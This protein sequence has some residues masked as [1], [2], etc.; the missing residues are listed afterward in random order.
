MAVLPPGDQFCQYADGPMTLTPFLRAYL[1]HP[2]LEHLVKTG[3]C[4]LVS[5]LVYRCTKD[6]L[7]DESQNR[8]HRILGVAAEDVDFLREMGIDA[9][10]LEIFHRYAG[11]KDRQPL[12]RWQRERRVMRDVLPVLKY[13]TAHKLMKYADA[14]FDLLHPRDTKGRYRGHQDVVSEYRDYLDMCAKLDYAAKSKSVLFPKNLKKAHDR[15]AKQLK[16]QKDELA[17]RNFEE[18]YRR[19]T[20]HLDFTCGGLQVVYPKS[21]KALAEEGSALQH[22]V[23]NYG[24]RIA[25]RECIVLFLR[26]CSEP[27][28]PFYTIEVRD[29]HITQL[30]GLQNCAPTPEV[31]RFANAW[32]R[33]VL[34][35]P[36]GAKAA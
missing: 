1:E 30:R 32:E 33:D 26:R 6:G 24:N 23:V 36:A 31:Q 34:Q 5:D 4:A 21:L 29:G 15:A 13:T 3:F 28:K 14:Q 8:T 9:T 11:I 7:L 2:R 25:N 20:G 12:I 17:R 22:C 27:E 18:A 19:I 35:A 16:L 10:D